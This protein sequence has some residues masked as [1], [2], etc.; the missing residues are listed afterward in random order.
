M[1]TNIFKII[2]SLSLI[3]LL[4]TIFFNTVATAKDTEIKSL[5]ITYQAIYPDFIENKATI[6]ALE[7]DPN[8]VDIEV[9]RAKD[10]NR[11]RETTI[12]LAKHY[13]AIAAI[14]GG[15]FRVNEQ[16][17]GIPAGILKINH[18]IHGIAYKTRAAIGWSNENNI[19]LI[20]RLQTKT[21]LQIKNNILPINGLNTPLSARRSVLYSDTYDKQD[22]SFNINAM[23]FI[24]SNNKIIDIKTENTVN[25]PNNGY[26]YSVGYGLF[27]NLP[28]I[29]IQ[30]PVV[31]NSK[32]IPT[33]SKEKMK[34]WNKLPFVLSG[35]PLLLKNG[36][37]I[38]DYKAERP[39]DGFINQPYARTAIGIL[40]NKN[41]LMIVAEKNIINTTD[42]ITI[43]ELATIMQKLGCADALNL[44]GGGSSTMYFNNR[45]INLPE[46]DEDESLGLTTIRRVTDAI[47]VLEKK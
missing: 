6:H 20:D 21:T 44:D 26:I 12:E 23:H 11:S 24:I 40:K 19:T 30:D 37:L 9:V 2:K 7:I 29:N 42:G 36:E 4:S 25:I 18:T 13:N 28:N 27:N 47:V 39:R 33:L 31:I 14:N 3:F 35:A 41:W 5:G 1:S 32:L 43:P 15:F 22:L 17:E 45:I 16:R 10:R 38:E 8:L 46:G 34:L